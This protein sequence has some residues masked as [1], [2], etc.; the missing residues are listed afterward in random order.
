MGGWPSRPHTVVGPGH[1]K[2]GGGGGPCRPGQPHVKN[3]SA[4]RYRARTGYPSRSR[5]CHVTHA[6]KPMASAWM[7]GSTVRREVPATARCAA[8]GQTGLSATRPVQGLDPNH[9]VSSS[10]AWGPWPRQRRG[11]AS[12][13]PATTVVSVKFRK[14]DQRC[15]MGGT[16]MPPRA[17][18]AVPPTTPSGC[19]PFHNSRMK[20][21]TVI[22][23]LPFS[24]DQA[25][26]SMMQLQVAAS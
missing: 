18:L 20:S 14:F 5:L 22:G 19:N 8:R 11:C 6:A 4:P 9:R 26:S 21:G 10:G 23:M 15:G 17:Q 2:V 7:N 1:L 3:C 25:L 12:A 16:P 24:T 13:H